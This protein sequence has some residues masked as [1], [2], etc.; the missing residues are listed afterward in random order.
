MLRLNAEHDQIIYHDRIL[1][2]FDLAG[3]ISVSLAG[4]NDRF[5]SA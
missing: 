4:Q 1:D 2:A 3:V 5:S